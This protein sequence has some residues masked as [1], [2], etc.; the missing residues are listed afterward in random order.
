M[1]LHKKRNKPLGLTELVAIAIGGMVG[2]GIFTVLGISV[3]IVGV[4]TPVA[5][6]IGGIMALFAAYSYVKLGLYY[7]GEG[8]SFTYF[9][10]AFPS[11]HFAP[12]IIGW[13]VLFG[14]I[15]GLSLYAYTFSAYAISGFVFADSVWIDP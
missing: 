13:L 10:K 15:S 3:S 5:I 12:S 7:R 4:L 2:G 6:S 8:A 1:A 11:S 9:E 14:Y